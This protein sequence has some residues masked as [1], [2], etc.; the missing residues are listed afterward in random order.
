MYDN[1]IQRG[2]LKGRGLY[3]AMG[4]LLDEETLNQLE[5]EI[6]NPALMECIREIVDWQKE[7]MSED[8][9]LTQY[10][11]YMVLDTV[12]DILV[13]KGVI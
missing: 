8:N 12:L 6:E 2:K 7:V 11:C 10:D 9:R 13:N 4:K 5:V 1:I 3:V